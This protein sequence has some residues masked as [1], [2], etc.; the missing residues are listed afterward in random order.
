MRHRL[1]VLIGALLVGPACLVSP[2]DQEYV[3]LTVGLDTPAAARPLTGGGAFNPWDA[4]GLFHLGQ[5]T[6]NNEFPKLVR[7]SLS[8]QGKKTVTGTWPD[9][10]KGIG[11]GEGTAGEV[12]VSLTA[13][14]GSGYTL[15]AVAWLAS[16][17]GVKAYSP[18]KT[19]QL[20]LIAGK[21]SDA[22]LDMALAATGSLEGSVGCNGGSGIWTPYAVSLVDAEAQLLYPRSLLQMDPYLGHFALTIKDVPV[23]RTG[24]LRVILR[25]TNNVEK[26][27]DVRTPTYA[28]TRA[29]DK[30]LV[31]LQVPCNF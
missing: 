25:N 3:Q 20:D 26:S 8:A 30:G 27:L 23:G 29:G 31:T 5:T 6:A 18:S 21:Q 28:V 22:T 9:P 13:P 10:K 4:Q 17:A 24:W 16:A 19:V 1:L 2:M 15:G 14:S 7:V 11:G 12:E